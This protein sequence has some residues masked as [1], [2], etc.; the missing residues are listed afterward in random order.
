MEFKAW[1]KIP[2]WENDTIIVTEKIDGTNACI[3]IG[4]DGE[5]GC[6]SRSKIITPEEDNYGFAKWA[7]EHKEE[8]MKLGHGYHYGEWYGLGIQRGYQLN[9]KRF[10]LFN[11]Y[12]P[13]ESMPEGV[14]KVP[15][16]YQGAYTETILR[17]LESNLR[18]KGSNIT[19]GYM[20][21]EGM[22]VYFQQ[23]K[24]LVKWSIN[25]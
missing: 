4:T 5:F 21:V 23:T 9:E 10:A 7:Y 3:Y 20:N 6:Q 8:L 13:I 18:T 1:P 19:P 22:V 25:K 24:R 12:R 2:R 15:I 11:T 17:E 16:L 14:S